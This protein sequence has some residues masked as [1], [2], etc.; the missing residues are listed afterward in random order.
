MFHLWH[1]LLLLP[2]PLSVCLSTISIY[3]IGLSNFI[4]PQKGGFV[5]LQ[6][7]YYINICCT[8]IRSK[9]KRSSWNWGAALPGRGGQREV[10]TVS[11]RKDWRWLRPARIDDGSTRPPQKHCTAAGNGLTA[12]R[13]CQSE[14]THTRGCFIVQ[15]TSLSVSAEKKVCCENRIDV[16]WIKLFFWIQ[17]IP[18]D[19]NTVFLHASFLQ[20][21]SLDASQA[22]RERSSPSYQ[23]PKLWKQP[24]AL[25]LKLLHNKTTLVCSPAAPVEKTFGNCGLCNDIT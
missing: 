24:P 19:G 2:C 10:G 23:F 16:P 12:Q 6:Q 4:D 5:L 9:G 3:S 21:R 15:V 14:S 8:S 18:Q 20:L 11:L 7:R 22:Q 1:F 25:L 13:A 17:R